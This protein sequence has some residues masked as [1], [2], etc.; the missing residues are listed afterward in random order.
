MTE[1]TKS[2]P[3]RP[4][5]ETPEMRKPSPE[6]LE[7]LKEEMFVTAGT[8][9]AS[10]DEAAVTGYLEALSDLRMDLLCAAFKK[11]RREYTF[12]MMPLPAEIREAAMIEF[13]RM[14]FDAPMLPRGDAP[15]WSKEDR[16][17]WGREMAE[18]R[19]KLKPIAG[20]PKAVIPPLET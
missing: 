18:L 5:K 1:N 4:T 11:L 2:D 14:Q 15:E 3:T 17:S 6:F 19:E 16:E 12:H 10:L 8:L 7:F 20:P 9:G 13:E